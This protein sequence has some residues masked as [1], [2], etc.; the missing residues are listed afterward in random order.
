MS[1]ILSI[2]VVLYIIRVPICIGVLFVSEKYELKK[3]GVRSMT[4]AAMFVFMPFYLL[5]LGY[6]TL[7]RKFENQ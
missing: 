6:V 3:M 1:F 5:Y 2:L 4:T 7:Q